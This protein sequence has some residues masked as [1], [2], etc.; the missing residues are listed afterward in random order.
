MDDAATLARA[1][2]TACLARV[3]A[4]D[5]A[6]LEYLYKQTSAKLFGICN[7]IL[8]DKA[9]AE[10]VLQEVYLIV[11]NR[12]TQFDPSRG[13]SP[14]TWLATIAR[15][16]ALDRR[17]AYARGFV[18]LDEAAD[19][20]DTV[21][22]ADHSVEITERDQRLNACLS[23]LDDRAARAIREAFFG[24]VT[25]QMLA[26]RANIPL[27]TMKSLVRRGLMQLKTCL[28]T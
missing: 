3:A 4:S 23:G 17:R 8:S 25:Y 1:E 13:V 11:W 10:D 14:I 5:H 21:P 22:L 24:G 6:A 27:A 9:A 28:E 15:N 18:P 26:T 2:L 16:R 20:A 19:I 7:R 12:A